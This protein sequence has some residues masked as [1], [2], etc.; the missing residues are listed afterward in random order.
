MQERRP[1]H[2]VALQ[3][4][5]VVVGTRETTWCRRFDNE[6][7]WDRCQSARWARWIAA[8]VA[9]AQTPWPMHCDGRCRSVAAW[10]GRRTRTRA[11]AVI[12]TANGTIKGGGGKPTKKRHDVYL[13]MGRYTHE[14]S[15]S[16]N[17]LYY[18]V[19]SLFVFECHRI[20]ADDHDAMHFTRITV[21]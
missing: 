7:S 10:F 3:R 14:R 8:A 21:A 5:V 12:M 9:R 6:R 11:P 19:I 13:E 18:Y 4:L 2:Q 17:N 1:Q 15:S 16:L 20:Q